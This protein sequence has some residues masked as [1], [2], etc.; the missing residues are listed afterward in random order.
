[1]KRNHEIEEVRIFIP[2][3]KVETTCEEARHLARAGERIHWR[4]DGKLNHLNPATD[5]ALIIG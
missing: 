1:M 3:E 2:D 5:L 4:P